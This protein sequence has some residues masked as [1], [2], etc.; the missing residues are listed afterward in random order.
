M[1]PFGDTGDLVIDMF[2]ACGRKC[3]AEIVHVGDVG[4]DMVVVVMSKSR[5]LDC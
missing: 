5:S 2:L 1:I 4:V 3:L